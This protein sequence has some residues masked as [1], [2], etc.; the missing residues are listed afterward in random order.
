MAT[1]TCETIERAT[2]D[3]AIIGCMAGTSKII[4]TIPI[5][6][7]TITLTFIT[8]TTTIT[9]DLI[10]A[11]AGT[12]SVINQVTSETWATMIQITLA[13]NTPLNGSQLVEWVRFNTNNDNYS[14]II[15]DR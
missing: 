5:S 1:A 10:W 4:Y 8:I 9:I 2:M 14:F 6:T 13:N 3:R 15:N 7:I 12:T 11:T